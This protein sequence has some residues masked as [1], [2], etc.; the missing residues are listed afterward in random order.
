MDSSRYRAANKACVPSL[1]AAALVL[2][3]PSGS[4]W[5]SGADLYQYV[6]PAPGAR[7]VS[8][9]NNIIL[10]HGSIIDASTVDPEALSVVGALSGRHAG[11]W[12]LSDDSKTLVFKPATK[13]SSG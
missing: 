13:F 12:V 9:W 11:E 8:P 5:P 7:L 3:L 2:L 10:R 6:S 1:V 4:A